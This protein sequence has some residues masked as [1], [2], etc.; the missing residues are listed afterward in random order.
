MS[1]ALMA[2]LAACMLGTA[3]LSGIFGMAGGMILIGVLM[4]VMPVPEAM[5]LHAV[6]QMA[7]NGWRA[8]L[9]WRYVRPWAAASFLAG[10]LLALVGW[11]IFQ[12]VPDKAVAMLLLGLMPFVVRI[13]PANLKP[14][15]ER[16]DHGLIYGAICMSSMLLSGVVGPLIDT[17]FL[18]GKLG[19]REIVATKAFC[20]I[21]GH[22][23]KLLYFTAF[24]T[25]A[26]VDTT[27]MAIAITCSIVG[28]TVARRFLEAMSDTQ[29]RKWTWHIITVV[30]GFY[31]LQGLY[32]LAVPALE[33]AQ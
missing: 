27:M 2:A 12:Y 9:W 22:L 1:A 6:T 24:A 32:L 19:R 7:A 17:F 25:Q 33:A 15:A 4:A 20:Q 26:A 11:S 13:L 14:D 28:T 18:G 21:V 29:Y 3:F 31:V 5:A 10:T 23:S 16:I 30:S 8:M